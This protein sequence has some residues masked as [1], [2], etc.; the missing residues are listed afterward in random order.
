MPLHNILKGA[1]VSACRLSGLEAWS[2][3]RLNGELLVLCYHGVVSERRRDRFGYENTVSAR[4][5]RRH[6]EFLSRHFVPVSAA[7]AMRAKA[8][9]ISLPARAALVT[10][11]DGYRNNLT[12]AAPIL[13]DTGVPG[14]FFVS[15]GY[16][17]AKRVMWPDEVLTRI[18]HAGEGRLPLPDGGDTQIPADMAARRSLALRIRNRC[19]KLPADRAEA[20]LGQLRDSAADPP[21]NE[22]LFGFMN[23]DEVRALHGK[24]FEIG[25]HTV[26]HPILTRIPASRLEHELRESKRVVELETG[27]PCRTVA[28]PNGSRDDV[29]QQVIDAAKA[30]GYELGFTVSER[31]SS[32]GEDSLALSRVCVQGHLPVSFFRFRASGVDRLLGGGMAA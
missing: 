22:E 32:P 25:S 14:L 23:W 31:F 24:G 15:T 12:V 30:A 17:G 5:F 13:C 18:V 3:S 1:A 19:K 10:F 29:S 21:E 27:A 16:I 8:G 9:G 28:Y 2:R 11:D 4:E 20:Y 7:D 6:L 26:D